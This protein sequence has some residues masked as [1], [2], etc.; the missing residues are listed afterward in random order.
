MK[1]R[2]LCDSFSLLCLTLLSLS[3]KK[4][5]YLIINKFLQRTINADF[6]VQWTLLNVIIL[7]TSFSDNDNRLITLTEEMKITIILYH[8]GKAARVPR[9]FSLILKSLRFFILKGRK[10]C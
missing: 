9:T 2:R 4:T 10:N 6:E 1:R 3:Y 5:L 7:G 8:K